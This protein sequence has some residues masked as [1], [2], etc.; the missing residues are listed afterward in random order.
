MNESCYTNQHMNTFTHTYTTNIL[1]IIGYNW[2]SYDH[3][4]FCEYL[5]QKFI[6][7]AKFGFHSSCICCTFISTRLLFKTYYVSIISISEHI[8]SNF[9][10]L[11]YHFVMVSHQSSI[12]YTGW[13]KNTLKLK[14]FAFIIYFIYLFMSYLTRNWYIYHI[15]L[16]G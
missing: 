3:N 2:N 15:K 16:H 9:S 12:G 10:R 6:S 13:K 5:R 7:F 4:T 14:T 11:M 1:I 8:Y